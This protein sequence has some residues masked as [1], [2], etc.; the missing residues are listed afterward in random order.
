LARGRFAVAG[1]PRRRA[2][3][4]RD[5]AKSSGVGAALGTIA[6]AVAAACGDSGGAPVSRATECVRV[7]VADLSLS[8]DPA[9]GVATD[10]LARRLLPDLEFTPG[11][12]FE[13]A[14]V[15][16][17]VVALDGSSGAG[18]AGDSIELLMR[19]QSGIVSNP[20][21]GAGLA[22]FPGPIVD[23]QGA[24][25]AAISFTAASA[26]AV[27]TADGRPVGTLVARDTGWAEVKPPSTL[28]SYVSERLVI[29]G[30]EGE[31]LRDAVGEVF[32]TGDEFAGIPARGSLCGPGLFGRLGRAAAG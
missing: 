5:L 3:A 32:A 6:L 2:R 19:A 4:A 23:G 24:A 9:C 22:P 17:R 7:E 16:L 18:A 13:T 15:P 14:T 1:T 26:I 11:L 8:S 27:S 10:P 29:V 31:A 28:P 30:G 12:C 21:A 25:H 20:V